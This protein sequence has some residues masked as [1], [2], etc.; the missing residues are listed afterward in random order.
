[1]GVNLTPSE[2]PIEFDV[3]EYSQRDFLYSVTLSKTSDE[4]KNFRFAFGISEDLQ[5]FWGFDFDFEADTVVLGNEENGEVM[6]ASFDFTENAEYT[7][8]LIVNDSV[9]KVYVNDTD[10]VLLVFNLEG[11]EG[12]RVATDLETGHFE[13][14]KESLTS[15]N[16]LEGDI[17]CCGYDIQKVVNLSDGNYRLAENEYSVSAG[18]LTIEESYLR[19]LEVNTEYKFRAVTSLTDFDFYVSTPE[20]GVSASAMVEK[21]Y[22]GDDVKFELSEEASVTRLTIDGEEYDCVSKDGVVTVSAANLTNLTSGN[23]VAKLFTDKGRPE[24]TFSLYES[25]EVIPELPAPVNRVF[26]IV[27]IVILATIIIG[28]ITFDQIKK[29][30]K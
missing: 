29:R 19:T 9:A 17:F 3:S 13:Y 22:R 5:A 18:V 15:L 30:S 14:S 7:V 12:G 20:V 21:Y 23:H 6:S 11:Y 2:I 25:V 10:L 26:F 1:M 24:A 27:D 8:S 28:Y 16:T 4:A